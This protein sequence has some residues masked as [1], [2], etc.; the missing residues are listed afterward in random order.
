MTGVWNRTDPD[1]Y[2]SQPGAR[3]LFNYRDFM[4]LAVN[5]DD[6]AAAKDCCETD[7]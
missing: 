7:R 6:I 4:F 2:P 3:K 1:L 5:K